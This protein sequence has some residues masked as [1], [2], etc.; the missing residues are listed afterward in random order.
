MTRYATP[1]RPPHAAPALWPCC[2]PVGAV[3]PPAVQVTL[4]AD[5][6]GARAS[7]KTASVSEAASSAAF[8][9]K[10]CMARPPAAAVNTINQTNKRQH[11]LAQHH[12]VLSLQSGGAQHSARHA[13]ARSVRR[14]AVATL[15][16]PS[17]FS[18]G[19]PAAPQ[20][21]QKLAPASR[22]WPHDAHGAVSGFGGPRHMALRGA[23]RAAR[24][25]R[26]TPHLSAF[27]VL[28]GHKPSNAAP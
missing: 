20:A 23:L 10:M 12:R 15:A 24:S 7:V 27:H 1:P 19:R 14:G 9:D 28:A 18:G 26:V 5:A 3:A 11:H 6:P 4:L 8:C 16:S 2:V 13:R 17:T 22:G 25:A 21:V